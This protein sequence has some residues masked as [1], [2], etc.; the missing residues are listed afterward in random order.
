MIF[1][2]ASLLIISN[3][4]N[5]S[6]LRLPKKETKS[7]KQKIEKRKYLE[8][9]CYGNQKF[10]F[11]FVLK[12]MQP[13]PNNISNLCIEGRLLQGRIQSWPRGSSGECGANVDEGCFT[14]TCARRLTSS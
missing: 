6:L 13:I 11:A 1:K 14:V 5:F 12:Y 8:R 2:L 3:T 4:K 7:E 10:F 9:T